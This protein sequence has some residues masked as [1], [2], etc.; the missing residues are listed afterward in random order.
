MMPLI[1]DFRE[2]LAE[3]LHYREL[4]VFHRSEF[5]FAERI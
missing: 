4:V 1:A 5:E 3:Q 2:L